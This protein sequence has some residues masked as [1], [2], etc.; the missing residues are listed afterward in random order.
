MR[1]AMKNICT[2]T[3][4]GYFLC[5]WQADGHMSIQPQRSFLN[6]ANTT[7]WLKSKY[8]K[9]QKPW[10]KFYYLGEKANI[11]GSVFTCWKRESKS[12]IPVIFRCWMYIIS[13]SSTGLRY[14]I[15]Q[16]LK[17]APLP[18]KHQG[19]LDTAPRYPF[20]PN[21]QPFNATDAEPCSLTVSSL[22]HLP[23]TCCNPISTHSWCT[24]HDCVWPF[25]LPTHQ[26]NVLG[27]Y[28]ITYLLQT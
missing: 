3:A 8:Q 24:L 26:T 7:L 19:I 6:K 15:T 11:P 4:K 18:R 20:R 23:C 5:V 21:T 16:C 28:P 25:Y 22:R 17:T 1:P 12:S 9:I 13:A 14:Y 10:T 27:R 2:Q